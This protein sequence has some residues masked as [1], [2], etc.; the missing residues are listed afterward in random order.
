MVS[1]KLGER[2]FVSVGLFL[3]LSS[4]FRFRDSLINKPFNGNL[5]FRRETLRRS[6]WLEDGL[7]GSFCG[8]EDFVWADVWGGDV[9][10]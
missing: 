1:P 7:E 10:M 9:E 5:S 4:S 2:E 6:R 8:E 3:F